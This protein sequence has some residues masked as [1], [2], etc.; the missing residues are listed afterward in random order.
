[1]SINEKVALVTG[2]TRGIGQSIAFTLGQ[3]G[4]TVVGCATTPEGAEKITQFLKAGN[5]K[6]FGIVMN[7]ADPLS[8]EGA[9][10]QIT[11]TLG[12]PHILVNNAGVTADNLF[13]RMKM[14]EWTKVLDTN[15]T[16][17]FRLIQSCIR[18]MIK[19]RW[20]R[21][22]NISSVVASTGNPGQAN[23]A[24]SKAA[25]IGLTKSLAKEVGSRGITANIVSPGFIDTDMTRILSEEQRTRLLEQI[26]LAR[27]GEPL[28]VAEA[29]LFLVSK[30][31]YITGE[32]LHIN[33]GLY[34]C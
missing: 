7:I 18:P 16:G 20:G 3:A 25:L 26:P 13:L 5:I 21:I 27:M 2:A 30:G 22:V 11:D 8:I 6:G 28:E 19:A 33:G 10:A 31:A 17:T 32:T 12:A 23:Y 24:A 14:E 9:L 4:A 29:V 34:M 15:L 1:M